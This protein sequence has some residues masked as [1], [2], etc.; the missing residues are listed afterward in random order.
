MLSSHKRTILTKACAWCIVLSFPYSWA[1]THKQS[2]VQTA[3]AKS[4]G[5]LGK[6]APN[7]RLMDLEQQA[8]SLAD[9]QG[10][11]IVLAFWA[12]WC[13]PCR[14]E[15]PMLARLQ[16][17]LAPQGVAVIPVAVHSPAKAMNAVLK[18]VPGIWSLVDPDGDAALPYG[19]NALPK[20]FIIDRNGVVVQLF[21]NK[22]KET[23]LRHAVGKLR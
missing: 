3:K 11:V 21:L 17:E 18:K 12:T 16:K 23:D 5:L 19:A 20:T 2:V 6:P 4:S 1:A 9:R 14:S 8:F 10:Q 15:L 7:F 13:P 22:V